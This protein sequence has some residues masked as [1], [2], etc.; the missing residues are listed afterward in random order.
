MPPRPLLPL[1][2]AAAMHR[3]AIS[4]VAPAGLF[5]QRASGHGHALLLL[6]AL[7]QGYTRSLPF[8]VIGAPQRSI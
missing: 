1:S 4:G 8:S 5:A 6:S 7:A 2:V 3:R